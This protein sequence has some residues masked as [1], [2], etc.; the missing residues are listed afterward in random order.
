MTIR[1]KFSL[2]LVA[3]VALSTI[4]ISSIVF[5]L[6]KK[7]VENLIVDKLAS[8]T[9]YRGAELDTYFDH[10][11]SGMQLVESLYVVKKYFPKISDSSQKDTPCLPVCI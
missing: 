10:L 2:F 8:F 3:I 6:Y 9:E 11:L 5:F 7:S 4:L 1:S